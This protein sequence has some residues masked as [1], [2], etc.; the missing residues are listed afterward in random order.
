MKSFDEIWDTIAKESVLKGSI[1]KLSKLEIN[2]HT[3]T[4]DKIFVKSLDEW[5]EKLAI[6]IAKNNF[7]LNEEKRNQFLR[8]EFY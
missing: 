7:N 8:S 2:G 6:N 3:E 4:V 1:Q 5:R